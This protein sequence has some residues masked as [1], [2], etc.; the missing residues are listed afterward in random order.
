MSIKI[1]LRIQPLKG[2]QKR[3][4][5]LRLLNGLGRNR[6]YSMLK[7]T[8]FLLCVGVISHITMAM[9]ND[10]EKPFYGN[11]A[12]TGGLG[13]GNL[14]LPEKEHIAMPSRHQIAQLIMS[15]VVTMPIDIN[16]NHVID[17]IVRLGNALARFESAEIPIVSIL[18]T[19][20]KQWSDAVKVYINSQI[21]GKSCK[22]RDDNLV[23]K[24]NGIYQ[25]TKA[26]NHRHW[27]NTLGFKSKD[28]GL[29]SAINA[30]S[31]AFAPY[32][33]KQILISSSS[34]LYDTMLA[35]FANPIA[36]DAVSSAISHN[37]MISKEAAREVVSRLLADPPIWPTPISLEHAISRIAFEHDYDIDE[38]V[39]VILRKWYANH[40]GESGPAY[41]RMIDIFL[42]FDAYK[43]DSL[44]NKE[45]CADSFDEWILRLKHEMNES[46]RR[47]ENPESCVKRLTGVGSYFQIVGCIDTDGKVYSLT[48]V[49]DKFGKQTK[50]LSKLKPLT[51]LKYGDFND[52]EQPFPF[53]F[54]PQYD[55]GSWTKSRDSRNRF[56]EVQRLLAEIAET[57]LMAA[58]SSKHKRAA[59]DVHSYVACGAIWKTILFVL[60]FLLLGLS[61]L[62]LG[63]SW[64]R[65]VKGNQ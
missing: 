59:K 54:L 5:M 46:A 14:S 52:A 4:G 24:L 39:R 47:G 11:L 53:W 23:E 64:L 38:Q 17:A 6:G 13:Y 58:Y 20:K 16:D 8:L 45:D 51:E 19:E 25:A 42:I 61:F 9:Y 36:R 31:K 12:Q 43:L 44:F 37:M 15:D 56:I 21:P 33:I 7:R 30:F 22:A 48:E 32:W 63:W 60:A 29:C 18:S 35:G 57:Q 34:G 27:E 3:R 49:M 41:T 1:K 50:K 10:C 28:D 26:T 2:Q 55:K 40:I 65:Y 62:L